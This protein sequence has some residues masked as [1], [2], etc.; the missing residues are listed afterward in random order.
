[1][2]LASWQ[3]V[4]EHLGAVECMWQDLDGFHLEALPDQLPHTSILWAW[5]NTKGLTVAYR[6]RLDDKVVYLASI[7]VPSESGECLSVWGGRGEVA[8]AHD[9]AAEM[10]APD[11]TALALRYVT[12][13]PPGGAVPIPFYWR[14]ESC[15]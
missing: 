7:E 12:D 13:D 5:S 2:K 10:G 1:M 4:R 8:A 9:H 14:A 15:L 11:P 3:E 6:L